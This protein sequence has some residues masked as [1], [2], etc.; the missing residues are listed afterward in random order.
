MEFFHWYLLVGLLVGLLAGLFGVGG[1]LVIVPALV[2]LLPRI[3]VPVDSLM[4]V[5]LGTSLAT[6]V[7]TG[8]VSA[9][10]HHRRSA[11]N[12]VIVRGLAPGIVVGAWFGAYL[13][14][15][16]PSVFLQ[17]F[18][19]L[20]EI[21]V[22]LQMALQWRPNATGRLPGPGLLAV[23]GS[24]IGVISSLVGIGGGSLTVPFLTWCRVHIKQAVA[25]SAACGVP[26][27]LAGGLGFWWVG[28]D[29]KGLPVASMGYL[30]LPAFAG[31][32]LTSV[33][34]APMGARLA[35][36]LSAR[37]LRQFFALFIGIV[38]IVML[39]R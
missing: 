32:T 35:H 11:V 5:A 10:S 12:W 3:G 22:A 7:I 36:R 31:I 8:I 38:G 27:A 23:S 33:F 19:G 37:H 1:G 14:D 21:G 16:L 24:G 20:F 2:L 29:E 17:R 30:Y 4:Q 25:T 6:I 18:F 26:I 34:T 28:L 13:A 15:W 39:I 9:Y